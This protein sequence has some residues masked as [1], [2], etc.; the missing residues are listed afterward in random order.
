M[1]HFFI[2]SSQVG[3]DLLT[4]VGDDVNHMKNVLRMRS[5]EAFT[6]A[7]ENGIFYRCEVEELDKQQVTAKILWK[8]EGSSELSSRIYLFQGLPKSDKMELIIQKAVELGAYQIVPVATRRAIVKLDAKKEASKLKR[9]QA[10]AEGA[11]KQSGRML[12]PE[13]SEVKTYKEALQMAKQL[14]V[15]VIPY[16][17]AKGMAGTREIFQ[18]IKPGMSVG[19]FIGPEGGFEESEVEMAKELGITPVTLGKRILRT[20]TAGLTTLSI[21]MYLLEESN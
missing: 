2:N 16:E 18:S 10:I 20:E 19:I 9:W 14:D 5:G 4:I 3:K 12:I 15:N 11:A 13:I 1:S 21:L 8:E 17:C 7:D 6:A